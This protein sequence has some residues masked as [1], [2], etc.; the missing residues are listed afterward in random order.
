MMTMTQAGKGFARYCYLW[1]GLIQLSAVSK[2][3]LPVWCKP[4]LCNLLQ[5]MCGV[6]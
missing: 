3:C 2:L 5:V 4:L 6:D 1:F